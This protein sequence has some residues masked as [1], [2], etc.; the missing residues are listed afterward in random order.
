MSAFGLPIPEKT[1]VLPEAVE[2]E[3]IRSTLD[4]EKRFGS[5]AVMARANGWVD[6]Y[7]KELRRIAVLAMKSGYTGIGIVLMVCL[8]H[9][10]YVH[11]LVWG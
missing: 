5:L 1:E 7:G 4:F 9:M 11:V 2:T 8:S 6:E 3:I 10:A